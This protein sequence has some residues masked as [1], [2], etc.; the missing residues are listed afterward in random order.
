MRKLL[1]AVRLGEKSEILAYFPKLT[2]I[3]QDIEN[4]YKKLIS[5]SEQAYRQVAEIPSQKE[6]ALCI[7]DSPFK[8]AM[9]SVRNKKSESFTDFYSKMPINALYDMLKLSES[10]YAQTALSGSTLEVT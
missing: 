7:M 9:F 6:F 4:K 10:K 5:D 1:E 8:A 2:L 3:Y